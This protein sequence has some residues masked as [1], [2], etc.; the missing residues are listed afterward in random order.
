MLTTDRRSPPAA[1]AEGHRSPAVI[2]GRPD[3]AF[4]FSCW[5]QRF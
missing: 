2:I 4:L 3:Q 5:Q 1:T